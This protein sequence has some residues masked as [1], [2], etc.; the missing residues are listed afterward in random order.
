MRYWDGAQWTEHRA[1]S[2]PD[3]APAAQQPPRENDTSG[4]QLGLTFF[5]VFVAAITGIIVG[6]FIA[7]GVLTNQQVSGGSALVIDRPSDE[8]RDPEG[9]LTTADVLARTAP[10]VVA[11]SVD[12]SGAFSSGGEGSGV[13]ISK[14]GL[15]LTNAHV[16]GNSTKVKVKTTAG[17]DYVATLVGSYPEEDIALL[18]LVN[19]APDII[20]AELGDSAGVRVG[21]EVIAIGNAL[22]LGDTPTVTKGIISAKDRSLD[23]GDTIVL[24]EL[25]QTDSSI[26]PGNSGGPLVD[27]FGRVIGVNTAIIDGASNVGFA[28]PV[29]RIKPLIA[30]IQNGGGT[31]RADQ[32]FLGV[33]SADIDS[34]KD[35]TL[36]DNRVTATRGAYV[37]EITPGSAAAQTDLR[38]NDV[39]TFIDDQPVTSSTQV[40]ELIRSKTV[41][42]T[43]KI[44]LERQGKQQDISVELRTRSEADN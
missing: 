2:Q 22:G 41:G 8:F 32:P 18:Q 17:Q 43:V 11:I 27:V 5:L 4:L 21:D 36:K 7:Y 40:A 15:L 1:P 3:Q 31:V 39:I 25:L 6:S 44:T 37:L 24:K 30:N 9:A 35:E 28:I 29:D 14:E 12:S 23:D 34:I 20:P 26:N 10:A 33:V 42:Q 38:V 13:I 19:P 16:I